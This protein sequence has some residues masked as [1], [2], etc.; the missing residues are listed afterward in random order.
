MN[1]NESDFEFFISI[2]FFDYFYDL[3]VLVWRIGF[4]GNFIMSVNKIFCFYSFIVFDKYLI[5]KF[6]NVLFVFFLF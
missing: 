3:L 6:D 4:C 5:D 1:K 2:K